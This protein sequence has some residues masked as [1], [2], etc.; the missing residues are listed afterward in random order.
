MSCFGEEASVEVNHT[1]VAAEL[2]GGA[3]E[4]DGLESG[5]AVRE[6]AKARAGYFVSEEGYG[7]EGDLA[8]LDVDKESVFGE[9]CEKL[10]K[11]TAMFCGVLGE[12]EDVI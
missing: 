11:V 12:D 1:E 2:A 10:T 8:F 5:D 3:R 4:R 7:G 9:A 6:G